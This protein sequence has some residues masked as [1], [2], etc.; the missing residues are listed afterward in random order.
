AQGHAT[1]ALSLAEKARMLTPEDNTRLIGSTALALG[2]AYRMEGRFDEAIASLE[3]ALQSAQTIDDHVTALVAVE[4][5]ALIWFQLGQLRR[6][7]HEAEFAIKRTEIISQVAPMMIGTVHAVIGQ[8]Y[9]EWNQIETAREML[10]HGLRMAQLSGQPTS[11]IYVCIYL[12]RLC[13]ETGDLEAAARYLDEASDALAQ[14]GP[15]WARLDLVAQQVNLLMSQGN[16][17]EAETRLRATGIP[18]EAPVT[19]RT[20]LIHLAWLRWMIS[21]RH[22]GAFALAKRIVQSA[23]SQGRHGT[24]IQALVLGAKA[25]GGAAWLARA[26]QLGEPEGYQRIFIDVTFHKNGVACPELIE[27]LTMREMEVLRLLAEG[28]SYA[29]IAARLVVSVN[30]VR[31]HVK[32]VYGKLGVEKQTQAVDRGREL[33]LI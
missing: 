8:V 3:E 14:G 18:A 9:Y 22:P 19:F 26:R 5:L 13:Q 29:E 2:V 15:S 28:L 20:D 6:L 1:E 27:Q 11:V 25:G 23:E 10:L 33:G 7:I 12:A 32:K 31:F 30:T 4:H 16:P 21:C 17:A 24:M